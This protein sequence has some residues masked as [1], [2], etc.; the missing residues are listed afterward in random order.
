M[1]ELIIIT[2]FR[3]TSTSRRSRRLIC[4]GGLDE[5]SRKDQDTAAKDALQQEL[6]MLKMVYIPGRFILIHFAQISQ[7]SSTDVRI[8]ARATLSSR[9]GGIYPSRIL[10]RSRYESRSSKSIILS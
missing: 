6:I 1:I 4:N 8:R 3:T 2:W 5:V 10:S 7:R 9:I